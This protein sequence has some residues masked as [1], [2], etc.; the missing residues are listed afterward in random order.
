MCAKCDKKAREAVSK[1]GESVHRAVVRGTREHYEQVKERHRGIITI[2]K[3]RLACSSCDILLRAQ[4]FQVGPEVICQ[5]CKSTFGPILK[6]ERHKTTQ[7]G[8]AIQRLRRIMGSEAATLE[9]EF[10]RSRAWSWVDKSIRQYGSYT[11]AESFSKSL[12]LLSQKLQRW[13]D[14]SCDGILQVWE[15]LFGRPERDGNRER[16]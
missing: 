9:V 5:N 1:K 13:I 7:A 12:V 6:A 4:A 2:Q 14:V 10:A 16:G 8:D 3:H 11:G 15:P